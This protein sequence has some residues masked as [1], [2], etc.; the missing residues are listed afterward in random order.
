MKKILSALLSLILCFAFSGCKKIE[1][2]Q[3]THI[4]DS[5][6]GMPYTL[7]F[8]E[9]SGKYENKTDSV[10]SATVI[11]DNSAKADA[12]ATAVCVMG[13]EKG[14]EFLAANGLSG[15]LFT[16]DKKMAIV[17]NVSATDVYDEYKDYEL[18]YGTLGKPISDIVQADYKG[19]YEFYEGNIFADT[20]EYSLALMG[21]DTQ[22]VKDKILEQWREIE[23][24]IS[25]GK[26]DSELIR[27]N[28]A[29]EN[30]KIEIGKTTYEILSIALEVY[31][32]TSGAFNPAV[33]GLS[34]M[35]HV[36]IEGIKQ[37]RPYGGSRKS[38]WKYP[39]ALPSLEQLNAEKKNCDMSDLIIEEEGGRYYATKK[40][41]LLKMDMGG[42]A[43]G[44]A[45]DLAKEICLENGISSAVINIAG[46]MY[47]INSRADQ[48]TDGSKDVK[49]WNINVTSPTERNP[50][51]RGY[52]MQM[53]TPG[54]VTIV[55]SG[56]YQRYY[57]YGYD[58]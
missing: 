42:I 41:A 5:R 33:V 50:L 8:D 36:D 24:G 53:M 38:S 21:E 29:A 37:Y 35:W 9:N 28:E 10:I 30:E 20:M 18:T 27:L 4:I 40:N 55:T 48:N 51:F 52:I 23:N 44:Y 49:P 3:V 26:T 31:E 13:L 54:N 1:Y 12:Y 2:V 46:N 58:K 56:D 19:E 7:Y 39:D 45:V 14:V 17:G 43:K 15:I 6:S 57:F 11:S 25:L 34:E 22:K 47:L 16:L 32:Q